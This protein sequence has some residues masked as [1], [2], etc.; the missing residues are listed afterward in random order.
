MEF[1]ARHVLP[2]ASDGPFTVQ[3]VLYASEIGIVAHDQKQTA[4][5]VMRAF[6]LEPYH[7]SL[8]F[9]GD[10]YGLFVIPSVKRLWIPE[11]KQPAAIFPT[12]ITLSGDHSRRLEFDDLPYQVGGASQ[13]L[14]ST[15]RPNE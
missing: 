7:G 9:V 15:R 13:F 2:N 1:I 4:T 5:A 10:A 3:D 14:D 6:N 11:R 8:F 12:E